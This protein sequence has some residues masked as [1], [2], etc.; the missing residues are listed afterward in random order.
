MISGQETLDRIQEVETARRPG[1]VEDSL[2][3]ETVYI[4]S[5]TI[6]VTGS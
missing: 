4:E 1:S 2:P 6:D 5:V 3:L